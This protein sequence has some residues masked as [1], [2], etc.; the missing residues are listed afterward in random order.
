VAWDFFVK[1]VAHD[2]EVWFG[3]VLSG[4]A[5]KLTEPLH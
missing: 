1:P 4:W 2:A 3:I 5:A